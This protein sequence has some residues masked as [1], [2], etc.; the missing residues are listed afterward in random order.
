MEKAEKKK[1]RRT[2]KRRRIGGEWGRRPN[3]DIYQ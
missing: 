3:Q 2:K 1:R